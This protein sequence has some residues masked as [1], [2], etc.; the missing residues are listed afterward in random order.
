LFHCL[1][2]CVVVLLL[3]LVL[4]FVVVARFSWVWFGFRF[5]LLFIWGFVCLFVFGSL[6]NK[7]SCI[8]DYFSLWEPMSDIRQYFRKKLT[9]HKKNQQVAT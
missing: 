9:I 1:L 7:W 8:L 2:F 6:H 4:V 3:L 5:C